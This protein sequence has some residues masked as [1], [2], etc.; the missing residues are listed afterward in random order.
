MGKVLYE[1]L[2]AEDRFL[3]KSFSKVPTD[4]LLLIAFQG[5]PELL[6]LP[7]ELL[8]TG[9]GFLVQRIQPEILPIRLIPGRPTPRT[10]SKTG[11]TSIVY[12]HFP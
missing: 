4:R 5:S 7:W 3:E 11:I 10:F 2:D 9:E 8:H 12:G 1:W 6:H